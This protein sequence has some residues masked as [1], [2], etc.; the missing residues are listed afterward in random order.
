MLYC[1]SRCLLSI[2]A[3]RTCGPY[4]SV[5]R[6]R[7]LLSIESFFFRVTAGELLYFIAIAE[8]ESCLVSISQC[9]SMQPLFPKIG[10]DPRYCTPQTQYLSLPSAHCQFNTQYLSK[11]IIIDPLYLW[12]INGARSTR[13]GFWCWRRFGNETFKSY[14]GGLAR[15][16]WTV[17][18]I[19]RV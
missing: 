11:G 14:S 19:G 10:H 9:R 4:G 12:V 15:G 5:L 13:R 7:C 1:R 17:Q 2:E 6:S 3:T 16:P 8:I 18:N